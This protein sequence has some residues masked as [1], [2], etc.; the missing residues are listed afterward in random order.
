MRN[1][2]AT[3]AAQTL[4]R[5]PLAA[6]AV[7]SLS[8]KISKAPDG[9][10]PNWLTSPTAQ[11]PSHHQIGQTQHPKQTF[12]IPVS[13]HANLY[14]ST[15][16]LVPFTMNSQTTTEKPATFT[17]D[18]ELELLFD[19]KLVPDDVKQQLPSHLHV[20]VCFKMLQR[21]SLLSLGMLTTRPACLAPPFVLDGLSPLTSHRPRS[22]HPNPRHG[23][24]RLPIP[25][26]RHGE[27]SQNLFRNRHCR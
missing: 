9:R 6:N 8:L 10:A 17:P 23:L 1:V 25:I 20:S 22:P 15:T 13:N 24:H 19:P 12:E 3:Y 14:S 2:C 21:D 16:Q 7:F 5:E 18:S 4:L 26:P 27:H 11:T